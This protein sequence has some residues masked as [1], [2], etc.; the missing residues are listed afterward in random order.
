LVPLAVVTN[1][2]PYVPSA[3]RTLTPGVA[4]SAARESVR[5]GAD[6]APLLA[7]SPAGETNSSEVALVGA[8]EGL[9]DEIG[10]GPG[11]PGG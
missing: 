1:L 3:T 11:S 2:P 7:S 9:L 6:W 5:S 4:S 8:I 10:A